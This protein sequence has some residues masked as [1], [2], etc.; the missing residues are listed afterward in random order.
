MPQTSKMFK[1]EGT[2]PRLDAAIQNCLKSRTAFQ[3]VLDNSDARGHPR[4]RHRL[5]PTSSSCL[6]YSRRCCLGGDFPLAG[7]CRERFQTMDEFSNLP[8]M[9]S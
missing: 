5:E 6:K 9:S 8:G 2:R 4:Q 1:D 3:G 7:C